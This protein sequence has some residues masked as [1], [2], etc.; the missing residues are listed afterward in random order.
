MFSWCLST[1]K[2]QSNDNRIRT[3]LN[4]KEFTSFPV[5]DRHNVYWN[6]QNSFVMPLNYLVFLLSSQ[7]W[8]LQRKS[9]QLTISSLNSYNKNC[10]VACKSHQ[11][12][13]ESRIHIN[14][15]KHTHT[16]MHSHFPGW[17][18]LGHP[19]AP[20]IILLYV[21][22]IYA[23]SCNRWELFRIILSCLIPFTYIV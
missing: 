20:L 4:V 7:I 16:H 12:C 14:T 2:W 18:N 13:A 19:V 6:L 11:K 10:D 23:P 5:T 1:V 9:N 15:I 8:N 17:I 3:T 22:W 21:F